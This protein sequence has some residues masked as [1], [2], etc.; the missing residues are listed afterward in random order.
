[1]SWMTTI[2]DK[3]F[4]TMGLT[5]DIPDAPASK[6][7]PLPA[8]RT[9]YYNI[10]M[11]NQQFLNS[12]AQQQLGISE[13]VHRWG[14]D[15]YERWKRGLKP[16]ELEYLKN[17]KEGINPDIHVSRVKNAIMTKFG[18]DLRKVQAALSSKGIKAGGVQSMA[19]TKHLQSDT[20]KNLGI[21]EQ[22][23]KE[24]VE[25]ANRSNQMQASGLG[26]GI[27][28]TA[29]SGMGSASSNMDRAGA[30]SRGGTAAMMSGMEDINA[31]NYNQAMQ[32]YNLARSDDMMDWQ[33]KVAQKEDEAA[34]RRA[35]VSTVISVA[36]VA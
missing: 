22:M 23:T 2:R 7:P 33:V 28:A 1:M 14:K 30:I 26:R 29:I 12:I 35:M 34:S 6:P 10:A 24:G 20:S 31:T 17:T 19:A 8:D 9:E 15:D 3:T 21:S 27:T 36:A 5:A 25:Q 13:E 4:D 18:G 11:Q 16:T 32:E